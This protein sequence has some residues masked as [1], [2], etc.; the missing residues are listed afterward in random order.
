MRFNVNWNWAKAWQPNMSLWS[1][2]ECSF[3][4]GWLKTLKNGWNH[5]ALWLTKNIISSNSAGRIKKFN[6]L[7]MA[8]RAIVFAQPWSRQRITSPV[9][10]PCAP[11]LPLP[12]A[13]P[14][15]PPAGSSAGSLAAAWRGW[16]PRA[17]HRSCTAGCWR[18]PAPCTLPTTARRQ[19]PTAG[20]ERRIST[21]QWRQRFLVWI[22]MVFNAKVGLLGN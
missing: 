14:S 3:L 6:R 16:T 15:G 8:L 20:E 22:E 12:C 2:T 9:P 1:P 7:H 19:T 10:V 13:L 17:G 21:T 11:S 18:N 5:A 4:V